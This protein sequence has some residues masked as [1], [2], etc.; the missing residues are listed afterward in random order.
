MQVESVR[1]YHD[2]ALFKEPG[3]AP[4]HWHQDQTYMPF[5]VPG[6]IGIWIPLVPVPQEVGSMT[7]VSGS[8][9]LGWLGDLP[10]S[11]EAEAAVQ[12]VVRRHGL[13]YTS[14]GAMEPGDVTLHSAWTLHSAKGN[15]T[16]EVREVM[17]IFYLDGSARIV[18]PWSKKHAIGLEHAVGG[19]RVGDLPDSGQNPIVWTRDGRAS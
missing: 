4:T 11:R 5:D 15:P 18:E 1:L 12:D 7:F 14:Y 19:R 16:T 17:N 3:G 8:H 10:W 13:G 6:L 2:Q 9:R